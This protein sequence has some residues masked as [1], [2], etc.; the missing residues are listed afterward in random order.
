[1]IV[2]YVSE[3]CEYCTVAKSKLAKYARLFTMHDVLRQGWPDDICTTPEL[4]AYDAEGNKLAS[5]AGLKS[6]PDYDA[7]FKEYGYA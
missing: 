7:F 6:M 1:M 5:L 2:L 3:Y 4:V